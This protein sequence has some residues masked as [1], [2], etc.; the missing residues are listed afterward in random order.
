MLSKPSSCSGCPLYISGKGFSAVEGEGLNRVMIVGEALGAS[1]MKDGLPFRPYAQ[2]GA[3]LE[4]AFYF[5]KVAREQFAITNIVSCQPPY[6]ELFGQYYEFDAIDKCKQYLDK[7]IE[8]FKPRVILALG[9]IPLRTLTGCYGKLQ[10][11]E[12]LQGYPMPA[13]DYPGVTVIGCYHPSYIARGQWSVFPVLVNCIKR[14]LYIASSEYKEPEVSYYPDADV[15]ELKWFLE[16]CLDN[17]ELAISI[18]FETAYEE[19]MIEPEALLA[20]EEVEGERAPF[21][22]ISTDQLITQVN[23]SLREKEGIAVNF[24]PQTRP[25]VQSIMNTLN[26]KIGYN[27]WMFDE[28]VARFNELTLRGHVYDAM[29]EMHHLYPDLPGI[30]GK[31]AGKNKEEGSLMNLQYAGSFVGFP[32]AWKHMVKENPGFYGNCDSDCAYRVHTYARRE[33]ERLD[34]WTGY[35][36]LVEKTLPVLRGMQD[37]GIPLTHAKVREFI[38]FLMAK[39]KSVLA[40]IQPLIPSEVLPTKQKKGLK[41]VPSMYC[42]T[43]EGTGGPQFSEGI[44]CVTC[45]GHGKVEKTEGLVQ[46]VFKLEVPENCSCFK[47]RAETCNTCGGDW[48]NGKKKSDFTTDCKD[49]T[50]GKVKVKGPDRDCPKCKGEGILQGEVVRWCKPLEFKPTSVQQ[51]KAYA[52]HM[53]HVIPR[54]SQ[55][56]LAMDKETLD[57]LAQKYG[58]KV[59]VHSVDYREFTKMRGTYGEGFLRNGMKYAD[60]HVRTQFTYAPATLQFSSVSPNVQNLPN[61]V[62]YGE[63]AIAFRKCIE[64]RPGKVLIEADM[65]SFHSQTLACAAQ[66]PVLL[67]MARLDMHSY[68]T[69]FL[70]RMPDRYKALEW[71]DEKLG[72]WLKGIKKEHQKIRDGQAK[73]AGLGWGFGLQAGRLFRTNPYTYETRSGFRSQS[74]AEA[75]MAALDNA[76]VKAAEYRRTIPLVAHQKHNLKCPHGAIRWFWDVR[77]WNYAKKEWENSEDWERCIAYIPASSAHGH[78]REVMRALH[79]DGWAE[80][81]GLINVV[82]DSLVWHCP[83]SHR[84]EAC[85]VMKR[86]MQAQSSILINPDGS[87]FYCAVDTKVGLNLADMEEMK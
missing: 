42:P 54:N 74:E 5:A 8:R 35:E 77:K 41:T 46:K 27:I 72:A 68:V 58:D 84:E 21:K 86:Y 40:D 24:T 9:V 76:F 81:F 7:A 28:P 63:L 4:R 59:Y 39:Q 10:T 50:K 2:S 17:P 22:G 49:C 44:Y 62:K 65:K 56:K 31:S 29:W 12:M 52:A 37:R 32:W 18:D 48:K 38:R 23:L 16:D 19:Y 78:M 69:S 85:S 73:P 71:D 55:K 6:N 45:D 67:R 51:L 20:D 79:Y 26:P 61:V 57:K 14:S 66:D 33:L 34:I 64:A 25:F 60:G 1:E 3:V 30:K 83:E 43:C 36:N 11:V 80:K 87:P 70:L 15:P 47:V 75:C 13:K 53:H 82:H